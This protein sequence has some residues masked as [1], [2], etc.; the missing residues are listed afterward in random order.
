MV[1]ASILD[2]HTCDMYYLSTCA[3]DMIYMLCYLV[4]N[5]VWMRVLVHLSVNVLT[6]PLRIKEIEFL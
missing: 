2:V 5:T 4:G 6:N 3:C 1:S